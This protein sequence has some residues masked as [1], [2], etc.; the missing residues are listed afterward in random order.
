MFP[1]SSRKASERVLVTAGGEPSRLYS[2]HA[3][4]CVTFPFC[5]P[6][7]RCKVS[8]VLERLGDPVIPLEAGSVSQAFI[9]RICGCLEMRG[10]LYS[11]CGSLNG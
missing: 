2:I 9:P 7:R 3:L 10:G 6:C 1:S 4:S 11:V 5:A 8:G